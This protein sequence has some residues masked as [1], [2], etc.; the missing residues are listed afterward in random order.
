[1]SKNTT[2]AIVVPCF[3]EAELIENTSNRLLEVLTKLEQEEKISENSYIYYVNDGSTDDTWLEIAKVV[4]KN[5]NKIK[6]TKFSTN[7][8]NQNALLAGLLNVRR[9]G[10][11][12]VITIDADLQQDENK[13]GEF[14]EKY[15]QGYDIVCGIRNNRKTDSFFKKSTALAFYKFMNLLGVKIPENHSDYRLCSKEILDVLDKYQE[16][17]LF[18]RG[19]FY[20]IGYK[21]TV[22]Y[23]DVKQRKIG[24]SKFNFFTLLTLAINGIT[25]YSIVPLKMICFLGF[26]CMTVGFI[27]GLWA[28]IAKI[29]WN[30]SPNGWAESITLIAFFGGMQIFCTGIVAEYLGQIFREVKKRPRYLIDE[31]IG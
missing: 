5:P 6:A 19:F 1:M 11:D 23:F 7:F 20:E 18:L 17:D 14:V 24:C 10:C 3:N 21:S 22:V 31:E 2:L 30:D 4:A 16:S 29:L 28:I 27:L 26:V 9:I 8:G 25:S 13:I 15:D 12:C